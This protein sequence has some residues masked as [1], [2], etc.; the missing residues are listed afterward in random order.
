MSTATHRDAACAAHVVLHEVRVP[1]ISSMPASNHAYKDTHLPMM[2]ELWPFSLTGRDPR[3]HLHGGDLQP[4][5][6]PLHHHCPEAPE[7]GVD[8][9]V[10]CLLPDLLRDVRQPA[11]HATKMERV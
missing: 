8:L 5:L 10:V 3:W 4:V 11:T 6:L 9:V 1:V 7:L 2:F